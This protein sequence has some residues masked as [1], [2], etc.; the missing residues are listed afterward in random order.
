[1]KKT[2]ILFLS[3]CLVNLIAAQER[4]IK[5]SS[6]ASEK[7]IIIKENKRIKIRTVD[8]QKIS[9]RFSIEDNRV[10]AIKDQKIALSDIESIKRNPLL[11]SVFSSG[12][13]IYGGALAVGMGAIIGIFIESSGFLL[14][15][16][17][18]A[19]I[20]AGI[21]SPNILKNYKAE[22]SWS[23]ELILTYK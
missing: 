11:L 17:G 9:G 20:Y 12:F 21:K 15:I 16:P 3:L 23:Y 7:K 5:I 14:A 1:M 13:L 6:P 2:T 8:G 19:M 18:A 4:V 10:I 22:D